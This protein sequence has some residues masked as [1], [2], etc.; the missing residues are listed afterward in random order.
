VSVVFSDVDHIFNLS[1][2][3]PDMK[4][5][6]NTTGGSHAITYRQTNRSDRGYSSPLAAPLKKRLNTTISIFNVNSLQIYF[7]GVLLEVLN[8]FYMFIFTL[9]LHLQNL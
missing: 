8:N 5:Q 2:K 3:F 1:K 7:G 6:E 4:F 9:I